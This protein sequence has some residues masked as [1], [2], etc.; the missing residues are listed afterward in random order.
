MKPLPRLRFRIDE[1]EKKANE[2][3]ELLD[4]IKKTG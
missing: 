2:I 3:D 1:A 4:Q